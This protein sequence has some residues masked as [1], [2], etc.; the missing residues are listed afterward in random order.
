M[1][2]IEQLANVGIEVY[3]MQRWKDKNEKYFVASF[4]RALDFLIKTIE[5]NK[6][7]DLVVLKEL[8]R[9]KTLLIDAYLGGKEHNT[10]IEDLLKY[11][12]YFIKK[13]SILKEMLKDLK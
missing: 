6:D 3:R 11:F 10:K 13:H 2:L 9:L 12:D 5:E 1:N 7:K 4:Q 8:T